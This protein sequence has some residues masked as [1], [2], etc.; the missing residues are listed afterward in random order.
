MARNVDVHEAEVVPMAPPKV[1]RSSERDG[2]WDARLAPLRDNP[3]LWFRVAD[4]ERSS[5][6]T[7]SF[8]KSGNAKG[9][10]GNFDFVSRTT[11]EVITDDE[12]NP[13]TDK[14]GVEQHYGEVYGIYLTPEQRAEKDEYELVTSERRAAI[15][16]DPD[17]DRSTL[18]KL[19]KR[20]Y[21]P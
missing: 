8:L 2:K 14:N 5:N 15:K 4:H 21:M 6:A 16:A 18:P 11:D 12:G 9:V 19:P 20:S 1:T 3:G 7:T 10:D 13:V 17:V